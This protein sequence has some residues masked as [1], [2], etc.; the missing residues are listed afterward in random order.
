ME[1]RL[2]TRF[3]WGLIADISVPDYETRMAIL[4]KKIE[5]DQLER[6]QI[7]DEGDPVYCDE[8]QDQYP[9]TGRLT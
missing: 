1:A 3:E 4:Y 8:H 6:Y 7:P 2:R 5:L 9:G